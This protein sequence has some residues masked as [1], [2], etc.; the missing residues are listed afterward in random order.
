MPEAGNA[1]DRAVRTRAER[2][3]GHFGHAADEHQDACDPHA[4]VVNDHKGK[5]QAA[6]LKPEFCIEQGKQ[7]KYRHAQH[8]KMRMHLA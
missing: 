3:P 8:K 7:Q 2:R 1:G 5:I 6:F 4:R